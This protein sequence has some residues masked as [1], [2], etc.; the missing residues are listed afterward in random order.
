MQVVAHQHISM[1]LNTFLHGMGLQQGQHAL[2]VSHVHEDG[3][4]VIAPPDDVVRV[5]GKGETG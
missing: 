3:L 4:A 2:K 1:H 5:S